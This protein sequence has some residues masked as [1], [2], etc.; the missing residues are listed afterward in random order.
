[1]APVFT[2]FIPDV[3]IT[4]ETDASNYTVARILSIT[5]ND[6]QIHPVAFYSQTLTA[7][8]LN[9]DTHDKELLAIFKAFHIWHHYL[10]GSATL[11][12][13]VTNHKILQYFS[14]SKVLT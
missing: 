1:M 9:Y 11:V 7:P 12:N 5:L 13:I 3:P 2:H 4:V 10:E 8:E 14:T 6:G